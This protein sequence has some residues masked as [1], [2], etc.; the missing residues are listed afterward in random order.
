ML[1][2]PAFIMDPF[3]VEAVP[4]ISISSNNHTGIEQ[5]ISRSWFAFIWCRCFLVFYLSTGEPELTRTQRDLL[6]LRYVGWR[7]WRPSKRRLNLWIDPCTLRNCLFWVKSAPLKNFWLHRV[8]FVWF[9]GRERIA[10]A[11]RFNSSPTQLQ[12]LHSDYSWKALSTKQINIY[13]QIRQ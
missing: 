11:L 8:S 9:R 7:V 4:T 10:C 3:H 6:Q 12:I 2:E 5:K 1:K 13:T